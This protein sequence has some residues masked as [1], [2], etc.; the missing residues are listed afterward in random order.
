LTKLLLQ[1]NGAL[2]RHSVYTEAR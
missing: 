1:E 2:L